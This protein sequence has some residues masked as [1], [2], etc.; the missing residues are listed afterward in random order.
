MDKVEVLVVGK[1]WGV[2]APTIKLLESN[3]MEVIKVN[4]IV[5]SWVMMS[6]IMLLSL[7]VVFGFHDKEEEEEDSTKPELFSSFCCVC[8]LL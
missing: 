2:N 1:D 8:V 3:R 4:F 6:F 5:V 7:I